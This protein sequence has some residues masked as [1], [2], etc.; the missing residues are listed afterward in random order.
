MENGLSQ[1]HMGKA[2]DRASLHPS[3]SVRDLLEYQHNCLVPGKGADFLS[4]YLKDRSSMQDHENR[5]LQF[6]RKA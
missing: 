1:S 5:L 6:S 3:P 2:R 4:I